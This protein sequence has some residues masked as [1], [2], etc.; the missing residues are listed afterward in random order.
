MIRVLV[1][2]DSSTVRHRLIEILSAQA[3]IEVVG[4]AAD[5]LRAIELCAALR[6]DM[7]TL[8]LV[9]PEL[10]G[11]GVTEH[12]MAVVPTP[13]L[14]V[15]ASFNRG[16]VFDTYEA[17]SAGA[18]DVLEKPHAGDDGWEARFLAS[19]RMVAR[20]KVITHVRA[21]IGPLG[22][23]APIAVPF[24]PRAAGRTCEVIAIGASTGG[25]AAILEVLAGIPQ[26]CPVPIVVV[27]HIGPT[28]AA[29][30]ADWL[31]RRSS[32]RVRLAAEGDTLDGATGQVLLAPPDHH[33]TFAGGRV[34]LTTAEPRNHCRPSIDVLFESLAADRGAQTLAV[35]LTGMG[36]DGAQGQLAVRR[37]GGTT[38]AQDE[39]T[40]I[41]Y[42]M[43]R[44]A[45]VIGA[46][47]RVLPL[48]EIGP[49]IRA[50]TRAP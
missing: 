11:L 3:D 4:D 25:P 13:I 6:P 22:R 19:V 34:R 14:I 20:I 9:L 15:S 37:A 28:F 48:G 2:D 41:V 33:L 40:S 46:A 1:V 26:P 18:V 45:V 24:P 44:E 10:D 43:P 12:I 21:R 39:P 36:R 17:L 47:E 42:G 5:G 16:D 35:L 27:L 31:E 23:T 8:D 29:S 50:L 30:F 32:R 38:I 49:A 7:I